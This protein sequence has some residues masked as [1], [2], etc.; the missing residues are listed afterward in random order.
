METPYEK[1]R[2][3]LIPMAEKFAYTT[4]GDDKPSESEESEKYR[5]DWNYAFHTKMNQ[6]WEEHKDELKKEYRF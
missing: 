2:N 6:L 3:S 4:V 5:A 1:A